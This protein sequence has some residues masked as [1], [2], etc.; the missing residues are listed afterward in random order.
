M[1]GGSGG[2]SNRLEQSFREVSLRY[3]AG[4]I[5]IQDVERF[6]RI[7]FRALRGKVLAYFDVKNIKLNDFEGIQTQKIVFVLVFEDGHHFSDKVTKICDSFV[8]KRYSLPE[9]GHSDHN[10]FKRKSVKIEKTIAD[11]KQMLKITKEQMH[12]YL[13]GINQT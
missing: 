8:A 5:E 12:T 2:G 3:V 11:T 4:T 1:S 6:K 10:A 13:E 9:G 7:L